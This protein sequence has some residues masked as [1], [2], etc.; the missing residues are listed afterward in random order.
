MS[1]S[2]PQDGRIAARVAA[3]A[4]KPAPPE[5]RHKNR[6][7]GRVLIAVYGVFALSAFARSVFQLLGSEDGERIFPTAPVAILLSLFAAAVYIVATV[8]L[9]SS[10]R[11]SWRVAFAAV[12]VELLGVLVVTALSFAAPDLFPRA[13]VWSHFGQG[14]GY[15]PLV[16]PFFGLWWLLA[17]RPSATAAATTA[18]T[19]PAA[20][21]TGTR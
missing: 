7:L 18:G 5:G 15:I 12:L 11:R 21:V 16:L 13:S 4:D 6:G 2:T 9:A 10:R 14:Y 8:E 19:S 17:H 1:E 20:T 3:R